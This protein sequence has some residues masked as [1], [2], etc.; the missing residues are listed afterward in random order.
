MKIGKNVV[1]VGMFAK[2]V[3]SDLATNGIKR[4]DVVYVAGSS[5]LPLD[6]N[7]PYDYRKY[8]VVAKTSGGHVDSSGGV[9]MAGKS[10]KPLSDKRQEELKALLKADYDTTD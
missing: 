3:T 9:M 5:F 1:E 10:L 8:F 4:D 2:V 7:K 6:P